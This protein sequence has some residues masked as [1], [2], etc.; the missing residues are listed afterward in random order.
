MTTTDNNSTSISGQHQETVRVQ[1]LC[2]SRRCPRCRKITV[3]TKLLF[4][5]MKLPAS[6][7]IITELKQIIKFRTWI[8]PTVIINGKVAS[9]GIYPRKGKILRLLGTGLK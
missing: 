6:F 9:R 7:E 8:L 3:K 5:E 4:E 1:I 2:P